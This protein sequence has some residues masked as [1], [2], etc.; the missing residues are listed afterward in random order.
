MPCKNLTES[1]RLVLD[2]HEQ[3]LDYKLVKQSCGAAIGGESLLLDYFKGRPFGDILAMNSE[4]FCQMYTVDKRL[5]FLF[6]KHFIALSALLRVYTG[7]E[8][9]GVK[10]FCTIA[11]IASDNGRISIEAQIAVDAVTEEI[12]SCG[13]CGGCG[14]QNESGNGH[15]LKRTDKSRKE[16]E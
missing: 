12:K 15:K 8:A 16:T 11:D 10:D 2:D 6:L 5:Q 3:L 9:G 7:H 1:L 4:R 13:H 14:H